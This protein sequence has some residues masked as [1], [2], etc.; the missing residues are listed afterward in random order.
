MAPVLAIRNLNLLGK[1]IGC[2]KVQAETL[3][4]R[5]SS[6]ESTWN[7]ARWILRS[8][9]VFFTVQPSR[10]GILDQEISSYSPKIKF[11]V[12]VGLRPFV[13][14]DLILRLQT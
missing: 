5:G 2:S 9:S 7:S 10:T 12:V 14:R 13:M 11:P 1:P 8:A 6:S 3:E 4:K